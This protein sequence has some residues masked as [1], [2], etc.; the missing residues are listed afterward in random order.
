MLS[1]I[2]RRNFSKVYRNYI[3]GKWVDSK[4]TQRFDVK[5][6]LTQDVIAQVPLSTEDEFNE[7]VA[8]SA[9]AFKTWKKV[10]ISQ[11]VRY[12]LKYQE[13]LKQN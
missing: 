7:A 11:R 6:P 12:M 3:N 13:L 10:P 9:E 5:C 8:A 1:N 2:S 4:A